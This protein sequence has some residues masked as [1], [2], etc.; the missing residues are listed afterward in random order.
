[1]QAERIPRPGGAPRTPGPRYFSPSV[2]RRRAPSPRGKAAPR[3]TDKKRATLGSAGCSVLFCS[4]TSPTPSLLDRS[5]VHRT[6]GSVRVGPRKTRRGAGGELARVGEASSLSG[7]VCSSSRAS[8][9]ARGG[10][11]RCETL[12]RRRCIFRLWFCFLAGA[13]GRDGECTAGDDGRGTCRSAGARAPAGN[14]SPHLYVRFAALLWR[15]FFFL[16]FSS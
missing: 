8:V 2:D 3:R 11:R 12:M 10:R 1:V 7:S 15:G 4:P 14:I 5:V 13:G 6:V 9:C 16:P